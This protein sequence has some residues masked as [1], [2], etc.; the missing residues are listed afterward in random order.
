[1]PQQTCF[2]NSAF[3][4]FQHSKVESL[5]TT[6]R[7]KRLFVGTH[8]GHLLSY[9]C[10]PSKSA[11]AL[12]EV[13]FRCV[14]ED[15][16]TLNPSKARKHALSSMKIVDKWK[17]LIGI[18]DDCIMVYDIGNLQCIGQLLDT[19]GCQLFSVHEPSSL[20]CVVNKKKITLYN[21]KG[22]GFIPKREIILSETPKFVCSLS[23]AVIA[24]VKKQYELIDL[25]SFKTFKLLDLEKEHQMVGTEIPA[26]TITDKGSRLLLSVSST[27]GALLDSKALGDIVSHAKINWSSPALAVDTCFPRKLVTLQ[28]DLLEIH[29]LNTLDLVQTISFQP[30]SAMSIPGPPCMEIYRASQVEEHIFVSTSGKVETFVMVPIAR[31]VMDLVGNFHYEEAIA[32]CRQSAGLLDL[33]SVN[34]EDIHEKYAYLL[35]SKGDYELASHHFIASHV[36]VLR[37]F[38][39]FAEFVPLSLMPSFEILVENVGLDRSDADKDK[40]TGQALSRAA[41][42]VATFCAHHRVAT[43]NAATDFEEEKNRSSRGSTLVFQNEED[44]IVLAKLLDSI[45]LSALVGCSPPKHDVV[46]RLLMEPNRCDVEG[47]ALLLS[48][49]GNAYFEAL[50]WLYRSN[51]EHKRALN[52]LSEERC[53]DSVGWSQKQYYTWLAEYL[54]FLW[55]SEDGGQPMLTLQYLKQV[56]RYDPN[57]GLNVLTKRPKGG[58]NFGGKSVNLKEVLQ[59]LEEVECPAPGNIKA[60]ILASYNAIVEAASQPASAAKNRKGN[61]K[62]GGISIP[63]VDGKALGL[64]YFEWL[65]GSGAAPPSMHDQFVQLLVDS[66]AL[67]KE[68]ISESA[69]VNEYQLRDT[70]SEALLILKV[71]RRKLRYFLQLSE[72]CNLQRVTKLLPA[73][74]LHEKA[75]IKAKMGL[76]EEALK[77]YVFDLRDYAAASE[78]CDFLYSQKPVRDWR[79]SHQYFVM[80]N[81][82]DTDIYT[83]LFRMILKGGEEEHNK[84]SM[85]ERIACVSRLAEIYYER[86]SAVDFLGL[87]DTS[88]PVAEIME[89]LEMVSEHNNAK[90]RTLQVSHQIMRMKEVMSRCGSS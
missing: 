51:G 79:D 81:L 86:I 26:D 12:D 2:Q 78:F 15:T 62:F 33:S 6:A 36:S 64:V 72:K 82:N 73:D 10:S 40:L 13:Q 57:L 8:E 11:T 20:L 16:L 52:L 80:K 56:L 22:S 24:G 76:F 34:V 53:V 31:Q 44:P 42:A 74:F 70:D 32:L 77:I 43:R 87:L 21:W 28:K 90:K 55:Y 46:R 84:A 4:G 1:M 18:V 59:L 7:C 35:Y 66:I 9:A 58:T 37:F 48:S 60:T 29:D 30:A 14:F 41:A 38:T 88:T 23:G 39:L 63:L 3:E 45:L 68:N 47:G 75:L 65:V 19:K 83:C 54:R 50:L 69:D 61:T 89:Y 25:S 17:V 71:L 5:V 49:H 67:Y 27:V 85:R